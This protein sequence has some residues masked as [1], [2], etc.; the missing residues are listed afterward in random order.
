MGVDSS[1][2][3]V[4]ELTA[5][6]MGRTGIAQATIPWDSYLIRNKV[7]APISQSALP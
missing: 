4:A 6:I 7:H 2:P 5:C 3:S 1:R